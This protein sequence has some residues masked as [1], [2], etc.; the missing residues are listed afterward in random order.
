MIRVLVVTGVRLY[1]EGLSHLLALHGG[2]EIVSATRT[3]EEAIDWVGRTPDARPDIVL[4]DMATTDPYGDVRRITEACPGA[5]VVALGV[6]NAESEVIA[7]AEAGVAGYVWRDGSVEDLVATVESTHRGEL[8]CSAEVAALLLKRVRRLAAATQAGSAPLTGREREVLG[9]VDRG[10]S[11][12]A[13]AR[14]LG[15]EVPTVKNHVHNILKK[16]GVRR[17]GQAAAMVRRRRRVVEAR[18]NVPEIDRA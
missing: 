7:C 15:I 2:L 16:L 3:A 11:N 18:Q 1:R 5:R 6:A 13:I 10:M 17:R 9:L 8:R 12:K 14:H 4:V